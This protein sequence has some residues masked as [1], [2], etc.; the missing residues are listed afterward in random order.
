MVELPVEVVSGS[1]IHV[2]LET[3]QGLLEVEGKVV[4][5]TINRSK[6]RHGL[7]FSEPQSLDFLEAVAHMGTRVGSARE[8]SYPQAE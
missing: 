3:H 8:P 1:I 5:T 4:W 7:A 2:Q 6:V